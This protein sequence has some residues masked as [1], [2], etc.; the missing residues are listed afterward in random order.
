MV[1]LNYFVHLNF[2]IAIAAGTLASGIAN[3]L[4]I[5][6]KIQYG[7]FAFFSTLCVYNVQRL[8]KARR[9]SKSPW[10]KWVNEHVPLIVVISIISGLAG[11][12][13]FIRL[14][15]DVTLLVILPIIVAVIISLYYVISI[16]D[17]N[18]RE[19]PYL[20]VHCIAFTWTV[21]MVVFPI[22]NEQLNE[23]EVFKFFIPAHYLY[24]VAVAI[25]FDIRDLK[26]DSI[27]ANHSTGC[28]NSQCSNH[29]DR[30]IDMCM[31]IN[32]CNSFFF[33]DKSLIHRR[34]FDS[35]HLDRLLRKKTRFLL[36][37]IDR[38]YYRNA[39]NKLHGDINVLDFFDL[40]IMP[41]IK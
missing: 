20:K 10:L 3:V 12:Y 23:W 18:L 38:W 5:D 1:F 39:R 4:N 32:C 34:D 6:N 7:L 35:N 30:A 40:Q 31:F 22:V 17:K 33:I 27:S 21:I 8:I 19:L 28:R 11:A 13:F 16:G 41:F 2:V 9:T 14:L 24:F 37:H 15:N 36:R 25:P 29:I 26:Y